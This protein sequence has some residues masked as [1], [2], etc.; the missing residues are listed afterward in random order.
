MLN[1]VLLVR[2]HGLLVLCRPFCDSFDLFIRAVT[3]EIN[4]VVELPNVL[5]FDLLDRLR[6]HLRV[7]NVFLHLLNLRVIL[8][9]LA[10]HSIDG[11]LAGI[12]T[13]RRICPILYPQVQL[14]IQSVNVVL[15]V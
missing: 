2:C 11:L 12:E 6:L 3:A 13:V 4:T 8:A 7:C 15:A 5:L 9:T 10:H 14:F 1:A